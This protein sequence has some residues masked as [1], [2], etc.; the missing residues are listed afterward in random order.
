M[1]TVI[2]VA[3]VARIIRHARSLLRLPRLTLKAV[4]ARIARTIAPVEMITVATA[5]MVSVILAIVEVV[6]ATPV[7]VVDRAVITVVPAVILIAVPGAVP[8]RSNAV[9]VSILHTGGE[10]QAGKRQPKTKRNSLDR[11]FHSSLLKQR[12]QQCLQTIVRGSLR[13]RLYM[14]RLHF[15]KIAR[16]YA[17]G[18]G[19]SVRAKV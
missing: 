1:A 16:T 13:D 12:I 11:A 15:V 17:A 5:V 7:P 19:A 9:A 8:G 18:G 10:R 14:V 2:V 4:E 3:V 6:I